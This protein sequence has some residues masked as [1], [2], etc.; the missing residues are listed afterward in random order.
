M[1][2]N[3][4]RI[5]F[6]VIT[7]FPAMLEP[8]LS[9]GVVGGA[10]Q[11]GLIG[12]QIIDPREF[13]FNVHRTV[14]RRPF[15]GGDGMVMLCEPLADSIE[16]AKQSFQ[17]QAPVKRK[18]VYLSPQGRVLTDAMAREYSQLDQIILIC[19]RYGGIDQRFLNKYVD[20]ELSIGDY[21]LS[22]GE[23]GALVVIDCI[24][25]FIPG[26]LH[27]KDSCECES[28]SDGL[29]E[30]PLFTK[31]REI[32]DQ[33]VPEILFSGDHAKIAD[34]RRNISILKT[35]QKRP[36]LLLQCK[37]SQKELK[38]AWELYINM[39]QEDRSACGLPEMMECF[40][41]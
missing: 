27:N 5:H 19:G 2:E 12:C 21:V 4:K 13:V 41:K 18:T 34:W 31:P 17:G 22:G 3:I 9:L 10:I 8:F 14:D 40:L 20:E 29:L 25:R 6:D 37:L 35:W 24:S 39:S 26:V 36:E 15:G 33:S 1:E 38:R 11:D 28:F 30:H 23:L 32:Y 16:K 7:L